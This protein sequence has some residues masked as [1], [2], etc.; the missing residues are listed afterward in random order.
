MKNEDKNIY[1]TYDPESSIG[2]E[3]RRLLFNLTN[4]RVLQ[5][6]GKSFLI[7]S[8]S[9]GEGKSTVSTFL[10]MTGAIH[11]PRKTLLIDADL[12]RPVIHKIFDIDQAK[13]LCDVIMKNVKLED[14]VKK[15]EIENLDVI[16]SGR[17]EGNPTELFDSPAIPGIFEAAK[18]Y[19]ELIIVDSA[20]V[21]PVTDPII[22][23]T[24]VD[25]IL[26]VIKAGATQKEVVSRAIDLINQSGARL[27][28]VALNNVKQ[29]L[30]YYYNHK[31][32]GYQYASQ[33]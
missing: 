24:E 14:C 33:K 20:P 23:G 25:G 3:F 29:A 31:Y 26:L 17:I 7:T 4:N 10:A 11:R 12:R 28:G 21:V 8:P 6:K 13:G 2:T 9:V 22:L 19:Y 30:P 27:L 5:E 16:T 32:Y 15:T 1:K 18:F